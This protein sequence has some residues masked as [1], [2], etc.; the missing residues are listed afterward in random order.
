MSNVYILIDRS[1]SMASLW[2]EAINSINTYVEKLENTRVY[3]ACFDDQ[4]YDVIRNFGADKWRPISASEIQPR[5][6]TPLYDSASKMV[7]Q[8]MEDNAEKTNLIV[9]TDGFENCS[10][11]YTRESC[12]ALFDA[13]EKRGWP[14]T[15]LGAN[16]DKIDQVSSS[17]GRDNFRSVNV[18]KGKLSDAMVNLATKTMAYNSTVY[19]SA[20][21]A[22]RSMNWTDKE[23]QEVNK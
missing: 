9:M 3:V 21:E 4:S 13:A 20:V 14:V 6:M 11:S 19:G 8:A 1:G 23:K 15:F 2:E 10:R 16:F 18:T 12:K 22:T 7:L 5:G 17:L